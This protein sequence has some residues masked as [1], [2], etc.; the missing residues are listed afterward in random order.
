MHF[1]YRIFV[2]WHRE[3]SGCW[4]EQDKSSEKYNP[5]TPIRA[6]VCTIFSIWWQ[7]KEKRHLPPRLDAFLARSL[8]RSLIFSAAHRPFALCT[9]STIN[10]TEG[11]LDN[12]NT[13][14]QSIQKLNKKKTKNLIHSEKKEEGKKNMCALY[15]PTKIYIINL[16]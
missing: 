3:E 1:Y 12:A 13:L 8:A 9:Q 5:C 2:M 10:T 6:Y 7:W 11:K 15:F 16:N 4:K 14:Q